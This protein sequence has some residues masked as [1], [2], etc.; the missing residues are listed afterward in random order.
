MLSVK[1]NGSLAGTDLEVETALVTNVQASALVVSPT[2]Y[3]GSIQRQSLL[4]GSLQIGDD[5]NTTAINIGRNLSGQVNQL[6]GDLWL[7]PGAIG[8]D[9]GIRRV[10][11]GTL[12]I[13]NDVNVTDINIGTTGT[14]G[15]VTLGSLAG[16]DVITNGPLLINEGAEVPGARTLLMV[17]GSSLEIQ[18]GVQFNSAS[19]INANGGISR[20]TNGVLTIGND[21]NVT[22]INIGTSVNTGNVNIGKTG[23]NAVFGANAVVGSSGQFSKTSGVSGSVHSNFTGSSGSQML[24]WSSSSASP[25][26]GVSV[27]TMVDAVASSVGGNN[28][29]DVLVDI[30]VPSTNKSFSCFFNIQ[31]AGWA[32]GYDTSNDNRL[33]GCVFARGVLVNNGANGLFGVSVNEIFNDNFYI[34][35][36]SGN[37]SASP[38]VDT[39]TTWVN[40]S[41]VNLG[42]VDFV[43]ILIKPLTVTLGPETRNTRWV[44]FVDSTFALEE[45]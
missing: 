40:A 1:S 12:S 3:T 10:L 39:S 27:R 41:V 7:V 26:F 4:A 33:G 36:A 25:G 18:G 9:G 23:T 34:N 20:S 32:F 16:G 38:N 15:D 19:E 14:T 21:A 5:A 44:G 42:G 45:P 30:A 6:N 29:D 31:V 24:R 13:G 2:V 43:R 37:P 11:P 35:G 28:V 17:S 8:V 22:G